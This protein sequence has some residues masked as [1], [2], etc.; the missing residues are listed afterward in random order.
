MEPSGSWM[1]APVRLGRGLPG[2][3][4]A[5]VSP[6]TWSITQVISP[7]TP[8]EQAGW[9]VALLI[10]KCIGMAGDQAHLLSPALPV[11]SARPN[12]VGRYLTPSC[13][14]QT[15]RDSLCFFNQRAVYCPLS[16]SLCFL[17]F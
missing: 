9:M 10:G 5:L 2:R 11:Y 8:G 4:L 17:V 15:R 1:P 3:A 16:V 14:L 12:R 7:M 6:I 13:L